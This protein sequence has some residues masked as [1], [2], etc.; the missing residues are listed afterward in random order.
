MKLLPSNVH[1]VW[2]NEKVRR[3]PSRKN[4]TFAYQRIEK[5]LLSFK[6]D[7]SGGRGS[8]LDPAKPLSINGKVV[9]LP[10]LPQTP[11]MLRLVEKS[12]VEVTDLI[13]SSNAGENNLIE[14]NYLRSKTGWLKALFRRNLGVLDLELLVTWAEPVKAK[15]KPRIT[16]SYCMHCGRSIRSGARFC[17]YCSNPPPRGG[18]TPKTCRNCSTLLPPIA[19]FC[20]KCG[21]EQPKI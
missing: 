13:R 4:F 18:K 19:K 12:N 5:V 21:S 16:K 11:M 6:L 1:H 14:T 20:E 3:P 8:F 9:P 15:P 7:L 2:K 17:P 10:N